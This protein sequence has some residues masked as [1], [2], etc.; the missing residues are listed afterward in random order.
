MSRRRKFG[1][2]V[3]L[4]ALISGIAIGVTYPAVGSV[5]YALDMAVESRLA[6]L[7]T[8]H[9]TVEA[10]GGDGTGGAGT[11]MAYFIGGPEDAPVI[12]MLH[13]YSSERDIWIRFAKKFTDDYRVIIPDLAGHGDTPFKE[14]ADYSAPAQAERVAALL[15]ALD[16]DEAH[17]IGNSMGGF[18]AATFGHRY[19]E[20]TL[21]LALVDAAGV[22]SPHP[23]EM[24]TQ[25]EAGHN[26]FL[27]TE[28]DQF[29]D[30]YAMT[31]A[32]PPFLP[33]FV[34]TAKAQDYVDRREELA[35]IF[36]GFHH[37]F[38]LDENLAEITAPTL[39]MWGEK[40]QLVDPST[41]AVWAEGLPN[42]RL[43]TYADLGHMPMI[44]DPDRS[45]G[46]YREFLDEVEQSGT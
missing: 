32:K 30:F 27:L 2:V 34:K 44:E 26:P 45:A 6:G 20:R 37:R 8:E 12:V 5:T 15:D 38:L 1:A 40:D 11:E 21:S 23:S 18:I 41:A 13:G 46:D 14:G 24:D 42:A 39:V 16:I 7:H 10:A 17:L 36:T 19:P 43:V 22:T 35:E 4:L 31:M 28:R 3:A 29:D 25:I 33:G 9:A